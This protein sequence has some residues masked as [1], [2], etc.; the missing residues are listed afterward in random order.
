MTE[1]KLEKWRNIICNL[2]ITGDASYDVRMSKI[3]LFSNHRV[4]HI[5]ASEMW[6]DSPYK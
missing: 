2:H 5:F 1:T 6:N 4:C 3:F